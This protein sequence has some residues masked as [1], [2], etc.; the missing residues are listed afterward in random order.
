MEEGL[1]DQDTLWVD[2]LKESVGGKK[3]LN[4]TVPHPFSFEKRKLSTQK[5]PIEKKEEVFNR[6]FKANAVP[7]TT[8]MPLYKK[9]KEKEAKMSKSISK[10]KFNAF[11]GIE[12]RTKAQ[13]ERIQKRLRDIERK[14]NPRASQ[15]AANPVPTSIIQPKYHSM[16]EDEERERRERVLRRSMELMTSSKLPARMQ[17]HQKGE[18]KTRQQLVER[19][20]K[21]EKEKIN[22][23]A[24]HRSEVPDFNKLHVNWKRKLQ[25]ARRSQTVTQS[26][27][28]SFEEREPSKRSLAV[29]ARLASETA[30]PGTQFTANPIPKRKSRTANLGKPTKAQTMREQV[31]KMM[32]EKRAQEREAKQKEDE[33]RQNHMKN[34]SRRLRSMIKSFQPK[35]D[36]PLAWEG[37]AGEREGKRLRREF[38]QQS[39]EKFNDNQ[40]RISEAR[41]KAPLLMERHD[42]KLKEKENRQKLLK[43]ARALSDKASNDAIAQSLS[44][45]VDGRG[46][47]G[48]GDNSSSDD[49]DDDDFE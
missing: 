15:F 25:K 26:K 35:R 33:Q 22:E 17:A 9:M 41:E 11:N 44:N 19:I 38:M 23:S 48:D 43:L 10:P 4:I 37:K 49:F 31:N 13:E 46:D 32:L 8:N 16:M 29:S 28:F 21:E 20:E 39:M 36:R 45:R 6:C 34:S 27:P 18:G 2:N 30:P 40:R 47:F 42:M 1:I 14:I 3:S 5:K 12:E 24:V 7:L